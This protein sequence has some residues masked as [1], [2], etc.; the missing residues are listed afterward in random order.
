MKSIHD[1]RAPERVQALAGLDV[2]HSDG[3]I[4]GATDDLRAVERVDRAVHVRRVPPELL[5]HLA[6]LQAVN[7]KRAVERRRQDV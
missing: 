1:K 3:A 7:A 4:A 6:A 5:Q 2:P